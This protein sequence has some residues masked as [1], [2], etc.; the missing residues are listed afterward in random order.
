MK[1]KMQKECYKCGFNPKVGGEHKYKCFTH[2]C[3]F[4]DSPENK[5]RTDNP[6]SCKMCELWEKH[7]KRE[8]NKIKKRYDI[9]VD[10]LSEV[11]RENRELKDKLNIK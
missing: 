11:V 6:K 7:Y 9:V 1:K 8:M 10:L 5:F 2:S 3:P 4:Y